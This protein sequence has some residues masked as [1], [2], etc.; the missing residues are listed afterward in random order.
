MPKSKYPQ[1]QSD[2]VTESKQRGLSYAF[3]LNYMVARKHADWMP[4]YIHIDLHA[5]S[6]FNEKAGCVGS[7]VT[8]AQVFSKLADYRAYFIDRDKSQTEL[9]RA[10][11]EMQDPRNSVYCSDNAKAL[12]RL[13]DV[14]AR[15]SEKHCKWQLGSI[16]SDPNGA[17]VPLAEII[18]VAERLPRMDVMFHWN[19]IITKRLRGSS[20]KPGIKPEQITLEM[21]PRLV[22]KQ[23]W[24][25][26]APLG[27]HQFAMLIGRNFRGEEWKAGGF[28]HLDSPE[29]QEIMRVCSHSA[30]DR[31]N[32][33]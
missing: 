31:D 21:L 26:R 27:P 6:G 17:S 24:L 30:R 7:P 10:R 28:Y 20:D 16:F 13:L 14:T 23:N 5:G 29:G 2:L 8:F 15:W 25:I 19:S 33:K 12:Q 22:H 32:G 4:P 9:L 18:E 1:G 11:P 3:S